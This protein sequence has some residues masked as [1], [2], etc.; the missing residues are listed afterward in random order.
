LLGK[1]FIER[2]KTVPIKPDVKIEDLEHILKSKNVSLVLLESPSNPLL[3]VYPIP[4]IASLIKSVSPTTLLAVDNTLA[5][6]IFQN[7]L[8]LGADL[9]VHSA[10]KFMAGHSD[11]LAGC[12]ATND[13]K[14]YE[15]LIAVRERMGNNLEPFGCQMLYEGL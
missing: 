5:T 12:I 10:T 6:P 8:D 9:V 13:K 3:Q 2:F 7:P 1:I 4:Q 15:G 11:L 14:L